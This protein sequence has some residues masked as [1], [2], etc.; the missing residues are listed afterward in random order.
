MSPPPPCAHVSVINHPVLSDARHTNNHTYPHLLPITTCPPT[1]LPQAV[2]TTSPTVAALLDWQDDPDGLS[3][4][5]YACALSHFGVWAKIA[6]LPPGSFGL[7]LE[8]D[9]IFLKSWRVELARLLADELPDDWELLF[10]DCLPLSGWNFGRRI[11]AADAGRVQVRLEGPVSACSFADAYL[12][13]PAAA[14][15]LL[16]YRPEEPL[17]NAE[18][19]LLEL[20]DRGK[21][22]ATMP[23]LALQVS[24][25]VPHLARLGMA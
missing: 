11:L 22:Y 4:K 8:D 23:R 24:T 14:A 19:L 9:V 3:D 10:L 25:Q 16:A 18:T 21:S 17:A 2:D 20:Q 5:E 13:T 12:I 15:T 6:A 1:R 7:V